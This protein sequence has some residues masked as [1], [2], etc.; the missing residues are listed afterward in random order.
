MAS[1][2]D[3]KL[4]VERRRA[5]KTSVRLPVLDRGI[6]RAQNAAAARDRSVEKPTHRTDAAAAARERDR[7]ARLAHL[8]RADPGLPRRA[9]VGEEDDTEDDAPGGWGKAK[10]TGPPLALSIA[11]AVRVS[12]LGRSTLY[13]LMNDGRLKSVKIGGRRLIPFA[14]LERLVRDGA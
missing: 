11:N 5:L 1:P 6:P 9:L 7:L 8:R 10:V 4:G 13:N 2:H 3:P 14:E 12:G